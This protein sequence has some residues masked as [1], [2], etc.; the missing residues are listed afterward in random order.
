MPK[1]NIELNDFTGGLFTE[2]TGLNAP[3]NTA[4]EIDNFIIEKTGGITKRGGLDQTAD[5]DDS[6]LGTGSGSQGPVKFT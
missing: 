5:I 6:V 2:H 1:Q 4:Q 3:A